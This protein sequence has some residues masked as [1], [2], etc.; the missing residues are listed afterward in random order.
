MQ[1]AVH[2]IRAVNGGTITAELNRGRA[3]KAMCTECMGF[4][5]HPKECTSTLCPLF[6]WRGKIRLSWGNSGAIL[7]KSGAPEDD[8]TTEEDNAE[9][10]ENTDEDS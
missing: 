8:D 9:E 4:E 7:E 6:P 2:T 1:R 10:E 5:A 3:I